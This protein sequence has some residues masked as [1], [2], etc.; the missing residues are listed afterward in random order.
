MRID[1]IETERLRLRGFTAEDALFAI[2]IWNDP[3]DGEYLAD[4]AMTEI[5]SEYLAMIEALGEDEECCYLIAEDK[6]TRERVGTCSFIPNDGVYDIA[7]CVHRD[8]RRKGYA[9]EMARGMLEY[10]R[11][12]GGQ[13]LTIKIDKRNIASNRVAEK[14]GCVAVAENKYRKRGTDLEFEDWLYELRL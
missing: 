9:T 2:G 5:D 10:A 11:T 12:H 6:R 1:T 13:R 3:E 4:E 8:H 7:Y 14:L